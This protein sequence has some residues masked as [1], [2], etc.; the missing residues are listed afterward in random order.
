VNTITL[1][2]KIELNVLIVNW[3]LSFLNLNIKK[4]HGKGSFFTHTEQLCGT[5]IL[6]EE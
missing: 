1:A 2:S 3:K 6:N 5:S 4:S